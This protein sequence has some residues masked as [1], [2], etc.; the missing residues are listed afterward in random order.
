MAHWKKA[1]ELKNYKTLRQ[2]GNAKIW[3]GI[4]N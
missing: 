1:Q 2:D 4:V 3:R